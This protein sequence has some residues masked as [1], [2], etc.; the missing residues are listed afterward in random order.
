MLI[1]AAPILATKPV[2]SVNADAGFGVE[3]GAAGANENRTAFPKATSALGQFS[4]IWI[5]DFEFL[6]P[7]GGQ[8]DPVCMVARDIVSG[9]GIR[10]W[11]DELS[12]LA[13]APWD[14][15]PK[16]LT[17]AFYAS[18]EMNC[19]RALGWPAPINLIDLYAEFRT[20]TNGL[21]LVAGNGL[22]GALAY[23]GLSGM[24]VGEKEAMRDLILRGGPWTL[25][26]QRAILD[27]C[28]ED[29]DA[30]ARLLEAMAGRLVKHQRRI[31]HAV[32]RGRY[33]D[34]VSAMEHAGIPVDVETFRPLTSRW[35]VIQEG[36]IAAVD[37]DYGV[38]DGRSFRA[39]R[40]AKFLVANGFPWPRL[41]SGALALDDDTFRAMAKVYPAI[42][43]L[44]ELRHALGEM[45]LN[46]IA[47]GEDGRNRT[48][49]S[50]FRSK[51]G[52][53]QPSN[54]KFLFGSATWL[55]GM[56]K[57]GDGM[58]IA[59]LDFSSQEIAIAAALSGDAALW[60]AYASGDPYMQFAIDAKLAPPDAT[61]STHKEIRARCKAIVL[62][63]QY[64]M[65]PESMAARAGMIIAE[66][67]QLLALHRETYRTFWRWAEQNVERALL[68]GEL[69]T[70][71][72]WRYRLNPRETPNARSLLNW[73][74]QAGGSDMLRL[75]TIQIV[76]AGV[77]LC[78]PVHD[79]VLIEAPLE[80]IDEHVALTKE[81][82]QMA[83]SLVMNGPACRVDADIYRFPDRYMDAERGAVMWNR[84]MGLIGGPIWSPPEGK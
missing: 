46:A 35:E 56:I 1:T 10:L 23:F 17:V 73:P 29:V 82:M 12:K 77:T 41:E 21:P 78:A 71:F 14:T 68:G 54:S 30:T 37:A 15:G 47:V 53:N 74:M 3:D 19:F 20:E 2:G 48:L 25:Q 43:P 5:V 7:V 22:L 70:P 16:T 61:K 72:G 57:P 40:F 59:Y 34:A 45:R 62:G 9:R 58:A 75:A 44:R 31:G 51:T 8:Q 18:A 79:A 13:A 27:Y 76:K 28:A 81:A 42:S 63:V 4:E 65:G 60:N 26:E 36:L 24:F 33:M 6:A 69:T 80:L 50:P 84:V 64:G 39:E 32:L 83:S 66:A 38:Y 67:R 55:R 49:L 11:R 52:R